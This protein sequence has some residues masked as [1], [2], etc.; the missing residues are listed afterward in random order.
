MKLMSARLVDRSK[1]KGSL[2][3]PKVIRVGLSPAYLRK[4]LLRPML[5]PANST[6]DLNCQSFPRL[7]RQDRRVPRTPVPSANSVIGPSSYQAAS[8]SSQP[9]SRKRNSPSADAK[10]SP[11][12]PTWTRVIA[13]VSSE[14]WCSAGALSRPAE[15]RRVAVD[16]WSPSSAPSSS[17]AAANS[18]A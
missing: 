16:P 13:V 4:L 15:P 1:P 7:P 10:P 8:V 6:S 9:P 5:S 12:R 18:L 2:K 14:S 17:L 11:F 3:F